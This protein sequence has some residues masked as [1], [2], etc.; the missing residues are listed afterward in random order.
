MLRAIGCEEGQLACG[1]HPPLSPGVAEEVI[2]AGVTLTPKWSNCSG[3]HAGMLALARHHGWP[4]EGYERAGHPVQERILDEVVRWTGQVRGDIWQG[5]DG[6][7]VVCF[8]VPLRAMAV[9]YAR[10]GVSEKGAARRLREAMWAHPELVA[11]TGRLCTELMKAAGGKVLAKV[12][13]EGVYGAALPGLGLGVALK[14]EDGDGRCSP[15]AL[16][17]VLRQVLE[18]LATRGAA[19][20]PLEG[21][22]HH[23]E[24]LLRNTRG[25]VVG[26]LR[27]AGGLRFV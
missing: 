8:G 4:T 9:A 6:C 26:S 1:P 19:D 27:P 13:A 12:G 18:R 5:V 14:V 17:A 15:P 7:T 20:V 10:F 2:R 25:V 11:G 21:L 24:P 23:A 3:K 22:A 16:L